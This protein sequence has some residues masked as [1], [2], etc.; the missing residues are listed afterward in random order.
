MNVSR[1]ELEKRL[2]DPSA[3]AR[4]V[5]IAELAALGS[6]HAI[7][8]L[9]WLAAHDHKTRAAADR[10]VERLR[11]GRPLVTVLMEALL[12]DRFEVRRGAA[13]A[14]VLLGEQAIAALGE[15]AASPN[16]RRNRL[17]VAALAQIG[18][19]RVAPLIEAALSDPAARR[20]A[21]L[22]LT[23]C[24]PLPREALMRALA[25]EDAL[26][27][28]VAVVGFTREPEGLA[29]CEAAL[30]DPDPRVRRVAAS[31]IRWQSSPDEATRAR[32]AQTIA[33]AMVVETDAYAVDSLRSA[34]VI[35]S[36]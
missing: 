32:V 18:G 30:R 10:A 21:I 27:R 5:A 31:E 12:D 20:R 23:Y 13:R 4:R 3:R 1:D 9:M 19:E 6:P 17:A 16:L 34:S 8:A 28:Y 25:H 24:R 33:S 15:L 22:S 36:A 35:F 2:R 7:P 11:G 14:L 26:V 29:V